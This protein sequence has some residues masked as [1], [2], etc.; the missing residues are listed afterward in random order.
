MAV[1]HRVVMG[2]GDIDGYQAGSTFKLFTQIA[3]ALSELAPSR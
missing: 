1:G 3:A 2:G